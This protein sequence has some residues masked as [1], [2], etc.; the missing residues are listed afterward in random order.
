MKILLVTTGKNNNPGDQFIRLGVQNLVASIRDDVT[1]ERIDK[2]DPEDIRRE[3]PFDKVILCGMP[4]WW[5]NPTSHSADIHWWEPLMRGWLSARKKDFLI[6][7]AG[8]VVGKH[9]FNASRF[10]AAVDECVERAFAVVTRNKVIDHPALIDSI[11]P[12]A[13][14]VYG[15]EMPKPFRYLKVCNLMPHGAH[16]AHLNEKEANIWRDKVL[17]ELAP[18]LLERGFDFCAHDQA[19]YDFARNLGWS[20]PHFFDNPHEYINFYRRAECYIGNRLHAGVV[21]AAA[22]GSATVIGYDSRIGMVRPLTKHVFKPSTL[23]HWAVREGVVHTA[24]T[25]QRHLDYVLLGQH[26]Q[27]QRLVLRDFLSQ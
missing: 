2:E 26:R 11:C 7:G 14:S 23:A 25:E 18:D 10:A 17:P 1:F 4:L 19:E 9:P 21:V 13:F 27:I 20:D 12:A 15:P 16:D 5:D 6:L 24:L 22:G 3:R 8:S